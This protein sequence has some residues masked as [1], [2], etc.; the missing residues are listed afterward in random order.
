MSKSYFFIGTNIVYLLSIIVLFYSATFMTWTV[1][2]IVGGITFIDENASYITIAILIFTFALFF[3][4]DKLSALITAIFVLCAFFYI[5]FHFFNFGGFIIDREM[6]DGG[7]LSQYFG[8]GFLVYMITSL[9]T[10]I[11][12]IIIFR[13]DD[14][15]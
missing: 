15:E 7:Y 5:V 4:D 14:E 1:L 2:P 8:Y 11:S 3:V 6:T 13:R 10:L 12:S 9:F